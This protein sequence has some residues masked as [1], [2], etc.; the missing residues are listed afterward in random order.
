MPFP[1]EAEL[2]TQAA[3][4]RAEEMQ[5]KSWTKLMTPCGGRPRVMINCGA[6]PSGKGPWPGRRNLQGIPAR[7]FLRI[8]M[9]A[10]HRTGRLRLV[11]KAMRFVQQSLGHL[12]PSRAVFPVSGLHRLSADIPADS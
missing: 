2:A 5:S 6:W 10:H 11:R 4:N 8:N 7:A 3:L 12:Q 9:S 1:T